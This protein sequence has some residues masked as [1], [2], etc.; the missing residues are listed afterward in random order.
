[1]AETPK[2]SRTTATKAGTGAKPRK[3][4]T[5]KSAN[6]VTA[7]AVNGHAHTATQMPAISHDD[8]ARLAH[9]YWQERGGKHGHHVE[10]WV[11]AEETLRRGA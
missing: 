9:V 3:A 11:R 5:K 1:M 2:K 4:A 8:V 7:E 10:D 6:G